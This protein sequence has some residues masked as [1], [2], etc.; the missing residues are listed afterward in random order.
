MRHFRILLFLLLPWHVLLGWQI[1][2]R[3]SGWCEAGNKTITI[4]GSTSSTSTPVQ[5]SYPSCSV[6]VYLYGTTT[7]ATIYSDP[8]RTPKTNPFTA[9]ADGTYFFYALDGR[10]DLKFSGGGIPSPFT[11]GDV[12]ALDYQILQSG[13]GSV[14]RPFKDKI[15][16]FVSIQD[17]GTIAQAVAA[18]PGKTLIIDVSTPVAAD[19]TIPATVQLRVERGGILVVASGKKLIISGA[20]DAGLYQI[21]SGSGKVYFYGGVGIVQAYP[22]WFG[23]TGNAVF[24]GVLTSSGSNVLTR[25]GTI[26]Q[27]FLPGDPI[28]VYGA[29]PGGAILSS[30][31]TAGST[32]SATIIIADK[33][34]TTNTDAVGAVS[35]DDTAALSAWGES[36]RGAL[37]WPTPSPSG[38]YG[39]STLYCPRGVYTTFTSF[40]VYA[41]VQLK[42]EFG[43]VQGGCEIVQA[44]ILYPAIKV[45]TKNYSPDGVE[46]G[47]NGNNIFRDFRMT[48]AYANDNVGKDGVPAI[49][50]LPPQNV[51]SDT[52][53]DHLT[54]QN[55]AGFC[56]EAGFKTTAI[57]SYSPGATVLTLADGSNFRSGN[58]G[59]GQIVIVGAG[60]AGADLHTYI[61]SGGGTSTVTI[62]DAIITAIANADVYPERDAYDPIKFTHCEFD[63]ARGGFTALYNASGEVWLDE[64][65]AYEAT[66]GLVYVKTRQ[67]F[68]LRFTN[69][70]CWAC[71]NGNN[72][73]DEPKRYAVY[74]E[75]TGTQDT[76]DVVIA[77]SWFT[78][79]GGIAGPVASRNHNSF[80]VNNVQMYNSDSANTWKFVYSEN[81]ANTL[82]TNS[83]FSSASLGTPANAR[84]VSLSNPSNVS[85]VITGNTFINTSGSVPFQA[86]INS[87]FPLT[88][89][90][91]IRNNEYSGLATY[92][93]NANV[94]DQGVRTNTDNTLFSV[95]SGYTSAAPFTGSCVAG[96]SKLNAAPSAANPVFGWLCVTSGSPGTWLPVYATTQQQIPFGPV[97]ITYTSIAANTCQEQTV[98][99]T[100]AVGGRPVFASPVGQ[101]GANLAPSARVSGTNTVSIKVCNVTVGAIT[102]AAI[103]WYGWVQ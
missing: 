50:L 31:V 52:L 102:P 53:F 69:G 99:V 17:Y 81:N 8:N 23:A 86:F 29:G 43:N 39:P 42:G 59:G 89:T 15:N 68:G 22:Q 60:T 11:A 94:T 98:T 19:L 40:T 46:E 28:M 91:I 4:Q 7:L 36:M 65:E 14:A 74:A 54:C 87:D 85:T 26:Y 38:L 76:Q 18:A 58:F 35:E 67:S 5:R 66:Y 90:S 103:P 33:A 92:L 95:T 80:V 44:S 45:N 100:G 6:T 101:L 79:L 13:T 78:A 48:S 47:G 37:Y 64:T 82:I 83:L 57:G 84:M 12:Q 55:T 3:I 9:A 10:Y 32:G 61:A 51:T 63:V 96:D 97:T 25:S 2:Q 49:Q 73:T 24:T 16:E 77:D 21:F 70:K 27:P 71:G 34:S 56:V 72:G 30:T 1:D 93:A 62:A 41:G 88:G 75:K 20:V